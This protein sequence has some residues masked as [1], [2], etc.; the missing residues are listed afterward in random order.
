MGTDYFDALE[1]RIN[2]IDTCQDLQAVSAEIVA[3]LSKMQ[4]D[5]AARYTV[6]APVVTLPSANPNSIL[7][8]IKAV[9]GP[10]QAEIGILI[11]QMAETTARSAQIVALLSSKIGSLGCSGVSAPTMPPPPSL[12]PIP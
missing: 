2:A 6:L 1:A 7:D 10:Y 3:Q 12:P 4:A 11:A 5:I 9:V 8:W